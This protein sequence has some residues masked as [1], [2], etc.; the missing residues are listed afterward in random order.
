MHIGGYGPIHEERNILLESLC[1]NNIEIDFWGYGIENLSSHSPIRKRYKGEA[2]GLDMYNLLINSKMTVTKHISS[3]AGQFAN[4][5]RLYEATGVGTLLITDCKDNLH[6]M[7]APGKEVVTY[8]DAD[9]AAEQISYYLAHEE[10]RKQ[11][12]AA[13]QRRTLQ[14]HTYLHRMAEMVEIV[15]KYLQIKE[16]I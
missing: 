15:K 2:W 12:A 16:E 3:V 1:A 9:E 5:M 6:E 8:R 10:E 11:I 4:N 14:E 7:F 13:G